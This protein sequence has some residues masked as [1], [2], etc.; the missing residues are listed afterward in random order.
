ML[1]EFT[2]TPVTFQR[3]I[4]NILVEKFNV[5]IIMYLDNIFIYTENKRKNHIKVV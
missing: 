4:N 1:F 5:S 3:Y 2:N